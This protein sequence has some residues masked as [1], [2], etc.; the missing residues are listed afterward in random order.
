MSEAEGSSGTLSGQVRDN[1]SGAPPLPPPP[2]PP[3]PADTEAKLGKPGPAS[4]VPKSAPGSP[5]AS[6]PSDRPGT[7]RDRRVDDRLVNRLH[8]LSGQRLTRRITELQGEDTLLP[9][10]D[11]RA[12]GRQVIYSVL[13]EWRAV[14]YEEGRPPLAPDV[15]E[16]LAR[17]VHDRLYGLGPIQPLID[18][19]D[20]VDIH[21]GGHQNVWVHR[22]DGSKVR[23]P[24]AAPNDAALIDMIARQARRIGRSERRW[25][26]EEV[27]L[28][29]QL[30]DGSRLHA[31]R[32]VTGRPVIDIRCHDFI[33]FERLGDLEKRHVA[34][35]SLR[36]FLAV[37][38]RSGMNIIV[39]GGK[40]MGKTT[41][42]RCMINEV[43][44]EERIITVEDSLELGI[45]RFAELHPDVESI[46][47]R[48]ANSE[49]HGEF[50]LAE[51]VRQGLRMRGR[52]IVGEV[53]GDEVIPMLK[54]MSAG[55][56]GSMCTIHAMSS[57]NVFDRLAMYAA[58]S[59][60]QGFQPEVTA[61]L[62]ANAVHFIVYLG[63][64][65]GKP[66]LRRVQSVREVVGFDGN[67]VISN[68]V[69]APDSLGRAVPASRLRENTERLLAENGYDLGLRDS[70]QG[71]WV[72]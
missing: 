44:P 27:G 37:V 6:A 19:P 8:D 23:G 26:R 47:A 35:R 61:M 42:L 12:L 18:D 70:T 50:T 38:V 57:A 67:Q 69:W 32:E 48:P 41:T 9:Y 10:E 63:W 59:E 62:V 30:P 14:A 36:D 11:E 4:A 28:D 52:I 60:G 68:E 45:E 17:E 21:I 13:A 5:G 51:A 49:G 22:A 16:A 71:L 20:V 54:A 65:F 34:D 1:G 66:S 40:G 64:D 3:P 56:D 55:E 24:K 46:E 7:R 53:R 33:Q 72:R 2:P 43:P 31:L 25:D 39:A 15:E 58:M 29:M